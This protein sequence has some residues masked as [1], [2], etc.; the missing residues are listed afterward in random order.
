MLA[1]NRTY[2]AVSGSVG[3]SDGRSVGVS[4]EGLGWRF[5]ELPERAR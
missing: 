1:V 3:L 4:L 2:N 5:I